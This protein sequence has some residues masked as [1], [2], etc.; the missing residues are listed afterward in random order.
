MYYYGRDSN[1][2]AKGIEPFNPFLPTGRTG[3][4]VSQDGLTFSRYRGN[5]SGGAIMDPSS[6]ENSF[7]AVHLGVSDILF[8]SSTDEWCMYYFGGSFEEVK[9]VGNLTGDKSFRYVCCSMHHPLTMY[10]TSG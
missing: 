8:D 1:M 2:W 10:G 6:D 7:D 9:L 5:L 4:A 3:M